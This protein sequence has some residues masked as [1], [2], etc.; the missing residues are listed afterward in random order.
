MRR[1][2]WLVCVAFAGCQSFS[3]N[4]LAAL[5]GSTTALT[6]TLP[7]PLRLTRSREDPLLP[8]ATQALE[9]GDHAQACELLR[10]YAQRHPESK[11]ARVLYAEVLAKLGRSCEA[12]VEFEKVV[13]RAQ[14]DKTL[15]LALLVHCHGRLLDLAEEDGDMF[16]I[17]LH[18]GL[19]LYWLAQQ[20]R[21]SQEP[22]DAVPTEAILWKS[23]MELTLARS[24][25]AAEARPNWYLH[26]AW[27]QLGQTAPAQRWL[28]EANEC[29]PFTYL[30]PRERGDLTL[31]IGQ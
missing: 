12:S 23:V 16:H 22:D 25:Q 5:P 8:Q 13:A 9:K 7:A 28:A 29:S 11:N 10:E 21:T 14:E 19:G 4:D 30:T 17:H 3:A 27:R 26:L 20:K 31:R 6:R 18:R 24:L 1:I 2:P 15:D